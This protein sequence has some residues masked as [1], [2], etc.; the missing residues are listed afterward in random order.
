MVVL[1]VAIVMV[2]VL[3]GHE[4][5]ALLRSNVAERWLL[6]SRP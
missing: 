2:Y 3:K 1:F 4:I 6:R 5:P